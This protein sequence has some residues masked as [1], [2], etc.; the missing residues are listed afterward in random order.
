MRRS[1]LAIH[2]VV[3]NDFGTALLSKHPQVSGIKV[4]LGSLDIDSGVWNSS[5][6]QGN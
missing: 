1:L 6:A 3:V 2:G 4:D 5:A